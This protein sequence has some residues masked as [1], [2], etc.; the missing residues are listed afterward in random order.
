MPKNKNFLKLLLLILYL[1]LA[2]SS[3]VKR[4]SFKE[5]I[6]NEPDFTAESAS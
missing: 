1:S 5:L 4:K 2:L 6:D 3:T